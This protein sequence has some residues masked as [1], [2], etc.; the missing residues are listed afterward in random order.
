MPAEIAPAAPGAVLF[1]CNFNRVRSPMAEALFKLMLGRG[2]FVDSCGLRHAPPDE[3]D[4]GD[5]IQ[6]DPFVRVVMAELGYDLFHHRAKT[7]DELEDSSF[8]LVISLTTESQ[9]RATE[10]ARGRAAD[11][12]YWPT[13][14]PTLIEGAREARLAAYR[15]VRNTL[16]R[17]IA[18]RFGVPAPAPIDLAPRNAL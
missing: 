1:T 4:R 13:S 5:A 2:V 7:F 10:L 11:I 17:R 12:E 3:D 16:A 14:D 6:A 18:E 15:E 9:N 8:D